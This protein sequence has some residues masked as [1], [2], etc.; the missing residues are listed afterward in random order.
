MR[1]GVRAAVGVL[2]EAG[3]TVGVSVGIGASV[4]MDSI[5][6]QAT[7]ARANDTRQITCAIRLTVMIYLLSFMRLSSLDEQ[8]AFTGSNHISKVSTSIG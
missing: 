8:T 5:S 7:A 4:G 6:L 3:V 1:V 2:V